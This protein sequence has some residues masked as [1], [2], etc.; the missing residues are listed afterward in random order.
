MFTSVPVCTGISLVDGTGLGLLYPSLGIAVQAASTM[1]N[2]MTY[3]AFLHN[4]VSSLSGTINIV[5][6]GCGVV[7]NQL[8]M[9]HG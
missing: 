5:V 6:A 2:A 9:A 3:A 7:L 8:Q 1:D 4:F